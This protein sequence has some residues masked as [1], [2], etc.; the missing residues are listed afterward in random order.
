MDKN[1]LFRIFLPDG[2]ATVA[3]GGPFESEP[4]VRRRAHELSSANRGACVEAFLEKDPVDVVRYRVGTRPVN[5]R[6]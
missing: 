4:E 3:A 1:Y 6:L 5:A 2:S